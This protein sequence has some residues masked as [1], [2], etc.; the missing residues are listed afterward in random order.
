MAPSFGI[1]EPQLVLGVR[2]QWLSLDTQH[3]TKHLGKP[4][5]QLGFNNSINLPFGIDANIDFNYQ[6]KGDYQN[7]RIDNN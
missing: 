7:I 6:S 1:W 3:G 5:F 4:M 2:K